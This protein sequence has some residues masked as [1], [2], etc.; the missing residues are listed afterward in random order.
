M[1]IRDRSRFTRG[2]PSV[3]MRKRLTT[4]PRSKNC[5]T[6][7]HGV[8]DLQGAGVD[9]ARAADEDHPVAFVDNRGGD[10][11][12]Q[13]LGSEHQ[14]CRTGAHDQDLAVQMVGT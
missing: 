9:G 14:A 5:S 13:Q 2:L 8:E 12:G 3:Y 6:N 7:I 10:A 1:P 11:A 4:W